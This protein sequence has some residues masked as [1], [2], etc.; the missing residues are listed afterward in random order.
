[1]KTAICIASGPSLTQAD[2]DY[3]RGK[4]KVYVVNDCYKLAP[5]ADVLY[6]C[7]YEWWKHHNGVPDFQGEK[8]TIS[9]PAWAEYKLNLVGNLPA[10][11]PWSD[12]PGHIATGR[13]SGFQALNLAVL[14][15]AER[16]IL[17]GY[18]M[19]L[20]DD[21]KRHWFGEHPGQLKKQSDYARWIECFRLASRFIPVPVINCTRRTA[22][23][24]FP[25][26][27]LEDTL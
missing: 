12:R 21:G 25:L 18:D 9:H 6:A 2:V 8:W 4:G 26:A 16:V 24:C 7:D 10:T 22:L 5:W 20:A 13:N 1:M 27:R 14:Q 19:G 15:G 17:L 23:D 11:S 3:C